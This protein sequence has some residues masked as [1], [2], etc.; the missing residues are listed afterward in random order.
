[1]RRLTLCLLAAVV[2]AGCVPA[3]DNAAGE[4]ASGAGAGAADTTEKPAQAPPHEQVEPSTPPTA[5][6]CREE[7]GEPRAKVLVQRC[8]MVSPATH[9]P[10]N[11][12]NP[13]AMI[14]GEIDRAC[15]MY[16][17]D[18]PRPDECAA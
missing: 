12:L 5:V 8:I 4:A 15:G 1:M 7:V 3:A 10:C 18:E 14:Q 11:V 2:L 16:G 9:P 6:S 13:C 17:P